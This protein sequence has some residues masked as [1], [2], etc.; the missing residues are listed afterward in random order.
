[1]FLS[2]LNPFYTSWFG[3]HH[4]KKVENPTLHP[5]RSPNQQPLLFFFFLGIYFYAWKEPV[6]KPTNTE[7]HI[8]NPLD[9]SICGRIQMPFGKA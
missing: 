2:R 4:V 6:T 1:M 7:Y 9:N 3:A 5:F 8:S